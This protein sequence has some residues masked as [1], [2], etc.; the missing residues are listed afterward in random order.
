MTCRKPLRD[1][2]CYSSF[3]AREG[4]QDVQ[5]EEGRGV[6]RGYKKVQS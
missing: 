1:P 3:R 2:D 6:Q 5:S 4:G